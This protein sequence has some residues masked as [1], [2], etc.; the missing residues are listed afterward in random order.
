MRPKVSEGE[1]FYYTC[2]LKEKS[3]GTRCHG[4]NIAGLALD[5]SVIQKLQQIF[6]PN[7]E[8]YKELEKMS[9]RKDTID[10]KD[11]EEE[12]KRKLKKNQEAIKNLVDKLKYMDIEVVDF[13]NN[14]LKK[15]KQE[16]EEIQEELLKLEKNQNVGEYG[17]NSEAENAMLVLDII[18][19]YFKTFECFDLKSKRDILKLLIEDMRGNGKNIEIDLLNTKISETDKRL[20]SNPLIEATNKKDLN[21]VSREGKQCQM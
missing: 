19:N 21:V 2:E 11:R 7:S 10:S 13:I 12:L 16:N 18:N 14:E 15:L 5:Q 3:R 4:K 20:L 1:R 8:I 6:V 9:I 17:E